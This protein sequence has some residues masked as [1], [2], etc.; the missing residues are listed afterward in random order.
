VAR[1]GSA[2]EQ[3]AGFFEERSSLRMRGVVTE[4]GKVFEGLF[5]GGIEVLGNLDPDVDME[6]S[7]SASGQGGDTLPAEAEDLVRRG[8]GGD[9][10]VQFTFEAGDA[11]FGAEG[12]LGKGDGNLAKEIVL[13]PLKNGMG[14]DGKNDIEVSGGTPAGAG[15]PLSRGTEPGASVHAGG[16]PEFDPGIFLGPALAV[17]VFAGMFNGL[18][19]AAAFWAG[20]GDRKESAV[21][22]NLALAPARGAGDDLGPGSGSGALAV[23]TRGGAPD[24]DFLFATLNRFHEIDLQVVAQVGALGGAGATASTPATASATKGVLKNVPKD[25]PA[26]PSGSE[27][28][29]EKLKRVVEA[30]SGHAPARSE[31]LVTEPVVGFALLGVGKNLVGLADLLELFLR[32]FVALVFVGMVLKRE[33]AI[34]LF[35]FLLGDAAGDPEDLVVILL[36]G[37]GSGGRGRRLGRGHGD[38]AGRAEKAFPQLE[39]TASL[40]KNG[41]FRFSGGRF[42][43]DGLVE[44]GIKRFANGIDG[45]DPVIGQKT[46]KLTLDQLETGDHRGNVL[47]GGGG[48]QSQF[49]VIQQGKEIGK[50]G[51]IRVFEGLLL[52][53]DQAFPGVLK[54]GTEAEE[55]ILERG[56]LRGWI[57]LRGG[58]RDGGGRSGLPVRKDNLRLP[59]RRGARVAG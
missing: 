7:P 32:L 56:D 14:T 39:T 17:T 47:G 12:E 53:P 22:G 59:R 29:P 36:G 57:G 51:L 43:A 58:C 50:D 30:A 3:L 49:E 5:L 45:R 55:L 15:F 44:M 40:V 2:L 24:G 23:G 33:L 28:L 4:A 38:H 35:D 16:N 11:D 9:F 37:H 1:H 31:G 42:R 46:L 41:A 25:G 18:A 52:F 20:L 54:I 10:E 13:P 6:I 34:R 8:P 21:D 19:G 27:D 26:Q 48:L